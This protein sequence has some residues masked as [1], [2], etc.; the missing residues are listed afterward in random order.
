MKRFI[1]ILSITILTFC[2]GCS[3]CKSPKICLDGNITHDFLGERNL[4]NKSDSNIFYL[5]KYHSQNLLF[6]SG[7]FNGEGQISIL[8]T[9]EN[10][11]AKDILYHPGELIDYYTKEDLLYYTIKYEDCC[12][13]INI[14][15]HTYKIDSL[16]KTERIKSKFAIKGTSFKKEVINTPFVMLN[17]SNC[18]WAKPIEKQLNYKHYIDDDNNELLALF[19]KQSEG[20]ILNDSIIE[21]HNEK[22]YYVEIHNHPIKDTHYWFYEEQD[23]TNISYIGWIKSSDIIIKKHS[24]MK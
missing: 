2:C 6:Y 22:W 9:Q 5:P 10:D 20:I 24:Y 17:D 12:A 8:Y 3:K 18:L 4:F 23:S 1:Y 21:K 19:P 13:G 15:I 7:K 14:K 11:T 16:L